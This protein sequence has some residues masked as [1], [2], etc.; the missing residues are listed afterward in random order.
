MPELEPFGFH[1]STYFSPAS[2][3][4]NFEFPQYVIDND[5][6]LWLRNL[7]NSYIYLDFSFFVE[8]KLKKTETLKVPV[9]IPKDGRFPV[10]EKLEF[11]D[12]DVFTL[13][14]TH[15]LFTHMK[16]EPQSTVPKSW[17]LKFRYVWC[18]ILHLNCFLIDFGFS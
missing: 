11:L 2:Y 7:P 9:F 15:S 8:Q 6:L 12:P 17:C 13:A 1:R 14:P 10:R 5:P 18:R 4:C 16:I 3:N